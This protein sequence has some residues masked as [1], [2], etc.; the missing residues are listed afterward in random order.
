MIRATTFVS[1]VMIGLAVG[2]A[3]GL[4]ITVAT[5]YADYSTGRVAFRVDGDCWS[6]SKI[7][8]ARRLPDGSTIC[9]IGDMPR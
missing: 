3:L 8:P 1:T 9:Y 7:W 5:H 6:A 4:E 2:V